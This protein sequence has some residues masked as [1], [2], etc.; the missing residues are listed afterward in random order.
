MQRVGVQDSELTLME[1][2]RLTEAQDV[3]TLAVS[4][5]ETD[6]QAPWVR[7]DDRGAHAGRDAAMVAE[8]GDP[9]LD[10]RAVVGLG[11]VHDL[12]GTEDRQEVADS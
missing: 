8:V 3:A 12:R 5:A 2:Q 10:E 7:L 4:V 1:D 6:H 11:V 9:P